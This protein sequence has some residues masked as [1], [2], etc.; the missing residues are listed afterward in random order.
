MCVHS[1]LYSS[2]LVHS[3]SPPHWCTPVLL[4]IGALLFSSTFVHSCSPP[5]WCTPVLLRIG[6]LLFSSATESFASLSRITENYPSPS[7]YFR[8]PY[9]PLRGAIKL[10]HKDCT[11]GR[12]RFGQDCTCGGIWGHVM[13]LVSRHYRPVWSLS[14]PWGA[15][16]FGQDCPYGV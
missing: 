1:S 7:P 8:F 5:H 9:C 14:L 15:I 4:R 6:A 13:S 2:A 10:K 12:V 16:W 3:C 11:C